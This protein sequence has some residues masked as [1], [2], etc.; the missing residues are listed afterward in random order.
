MS[1]RKT[2]R[3]VGR[4][5]GWM[6]QVSLEREMLHSVPAFGELPRGRNG[7][8]SLSCRQSQGRQR[9]SVATVSAAYRLRGQ[10]FA[11]SLMTALRCIEIGSSERN[12]AFE[13]HT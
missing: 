2:R 3:T 1:A 7:P 5:I 11:L 13:A 12:S 8:L 6:N 9:E 10:K 4:N